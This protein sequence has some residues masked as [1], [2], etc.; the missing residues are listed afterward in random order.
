MINNNNIKFDP[1]PSEL[2]V[3]SIKHQNFNISSTGALLAYSGKNTGRCPRD[4][5]IALDESTKNIW[6]GSVNIPISIDLYNTYK[7]AAVDYLENHP[8]IYQVNAYAG[9][10]LEN[11]IKI[12]LYTTNA[13][14]ALFFRNLLIPTEEKFDDNDSCFKIYDTSELLLSSIEIPENIKSDSTLTDTLIALNFTSKDMLIYGTQYAG[15]IKKG[16]LTLMMYLMPIKN[17]LCLH[18]SANIVDDNLCLFFGLSGTGKTTLSADPKRYLIGDDEHVWTEK[19]VFNV[20][21]GCYAKCINLSKENEPDIYN[22]IRYGAVLENV[23]HDKKFNVKYSDST[24]TEN[25]RCAYPLHYIDNAIIP[26]SV[27]IHP[28]NVVFLMCDSFGLLPP[29]AL[30][31]HEQAIDFFIAGYTSKIAGTEIGITE[32]QAT[33]SSCFGEPFLVWHPKQYGELLKQ[34]LSK[35]QPNVWVLNTGWING[36]Y[37]IGNRISI[38]ITRKILDAIHDGTLVTQQFT[39]F[40]IFDIKIPINYTGIDES[41][42]DPRKSYPNIDSYMDKLQVL[43]DKFYDKINKL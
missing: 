14:H 20:E 30:L 38:S 41:I 4:K 26:A 12:I 42:F 39:N 11:R 22:A 31:S 36:P 7:Y 19:G 10:D 2:Y 16:V 24:I 27:D 17:Y 23:V 6:W 3:D 28:V 35:Y 29:V 37:G 18:S 21:G 5:R 15:E 25:T 1:T 43:H 32:P 33:F 8:N 40:P 9:W 13:Y 34:K